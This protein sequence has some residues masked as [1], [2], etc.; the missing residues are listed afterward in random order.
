M[1][2]SFSAWFSIATVF[3]KAKR[4]HE[5]VL[6]C[7]LLPTFLNQLKEDDCRDTRFYA[8][9]AKYTTISSWEVAGH[10]CIDSRN[11]K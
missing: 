9:A 5:R 11:L 10:K 2:V 8:A 7:T 4:T 3:Q 1:D 6:E